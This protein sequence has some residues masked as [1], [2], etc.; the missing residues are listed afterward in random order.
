M[1]I[2]GTILLKMKYIKTKHKRITCVSWSSPK[3]ELETNFLDFENRS[4]EN[5]SFFQYEVS[6]YF[7][8]LYSLTY[9]FLL[10]VLETSM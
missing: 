6:K 4:F 8:F 3:T 1:K 10:L 9:S 5:V 7:T 2:L